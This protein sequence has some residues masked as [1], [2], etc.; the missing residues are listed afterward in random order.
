M[1]NVPRLP[2]DVVGDSGL[3]SHTP[4]L[5]ISFWELWE[6]V[7]SDR[8]D[9]DVQELIRFRSARHADCFG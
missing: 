2:E 5:R 8:A 6:Q 3:L 9:A 7:W 1:S 4:S